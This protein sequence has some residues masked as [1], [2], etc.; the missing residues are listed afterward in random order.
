IDWTPAW[1][2]DSD[3]SRLVPLAYCYAETPTDSGR[4][5]CDHNPNGTASG[6]CLEEA[7]LHGFLELVERDAAAIWWYN[8]L[9][10]PAVALAAFGD[11][12][13]DRLV[14]EYAALGFSVW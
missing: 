13:F 3:E 2:L 8:E 11:P 5:F 14:A 1:S 9:P 7:I 12:F 10:Q 4:V 6:N